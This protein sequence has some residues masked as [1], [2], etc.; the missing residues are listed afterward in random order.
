MQIESQN[1]FIK[2][3]NEGCSLFTGAGFSLYAKDI[4]EKNLL[5]GEELEKLLVKQ[6]NVPALPL[7]KISTILEKTNKEQFYKLLKEKYTVVSYPDFYKNI[8]SSSIK[9]W[10]TTNIDNLP[11]K[12]FEN[13]D[14]Y[15]LN[16]N[17]IH[18]P[19]FSERNAIEYYPLH[20]CVENKDKPFIFTNLEI[21][22]TFKNS[23]RFWNDLAYSIEK[24]PTIFWGYS[25]NDSGVL[26]T[27]NSINLQ[28]IERKQKW[29]VLHKENPEEEI[30]FKALGFNIIIA[31]TEELLLFIKENAIEAIAKPEKKQPKSYLEK[32]LF[33]QTLKT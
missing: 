33:L 31:N 10:F 17:S 21:A 29:I 7:P 24:F 9:F 11:H 1:L 32:N 19:T 20:G 3:I 14:K 22:S 28:T 16:D 26:E 30:Y 8:E 2:A 18:G 27:L 5:L 15:Y 13:S 4:D 6:F 12:I 23:S 25:L